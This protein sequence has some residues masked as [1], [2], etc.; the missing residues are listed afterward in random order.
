MA[1]G[2]NLSSASGRRWSR[3]PGRVLDLTKQKNKAGFLQGPGRYLPWATLECDSPH[4]L[5][6]P[7]SNCCEA[8]VWPVPLGARALLRDDNCKSLL[9]G[10]GKTGLWGFFFQLEEMAKRRRRLSASVGTKSVCPAEC[11][12][13]QL[14]SLH[15]CSPTDG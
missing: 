13:G 7:R 10:R 12:W 3:G 9:Q 4:L 1:C 5:S 6:S 14:F 2:G 11:V 15:Y 8:N